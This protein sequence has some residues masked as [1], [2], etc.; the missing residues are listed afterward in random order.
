MNNISS[1]LTTFTEIFS[2]WIPE[3]FHRIEDKKFQFV[4]LDVDLY[5]PTRDSLYFF[6]SALLCFFLKLSRKSIDPH[7]FL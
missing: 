1:T 5:E 6:F 2:G 3:K 7:S 4:H